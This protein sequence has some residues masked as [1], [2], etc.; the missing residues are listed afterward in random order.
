MC[1]CEYVVLGGVAAIGAVAIVYA[2]AILVIRI[3]TM[4]LRMRMRRVLYGPRH[5]P[6]PVP[7]RF[8]RSPC[9]EISKCVQ[10]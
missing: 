5:R 4:R 9:V 7:L 3:E 10:Q 6:W 1:L 8:R 2:L